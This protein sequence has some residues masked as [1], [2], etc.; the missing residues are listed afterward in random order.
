MQLCSESFMKE[1][2]PFCIMSMVHDAD[3]IPGVHGHDFIELV[4]VVS[5]QA[6]HMFQHESYQ[7]SAG[8]VFIINPGEVH[9]YS[10]DPGHE[11]EII[12]CLFL[13]HLIKDSLLS[14]L[15]ISH[16]MD[17]FYVHPF[18]N[19]NDRFHHRLN[20]A[21][22]EAVR[23]LSI[24]Q[25]MMYEMDA[26]QT[27]Y[28]TLIRMQMVELL[29]ILSRY[30]QLSREQKTLCH[31][32]EN[33]LIAARICGYLERHY[34]QKI[35]LNQLSDLFHIST[36]QLNRVFK[37]ET[38]MSVIEKVHQ[39]RLTRAKALLSET[40][41]KVISIAA[42]V[43]YEDPAFFSRLFSRHIGCSPSHYRSRI[44]SQPS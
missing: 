38:G 39:I 13:P 1:K 5:G 42:L 14:E 16:S 27:G 6:R 2:F 35:T 25:N 34:D 33:A 21:G 17:Y 8:D 4:Y 26:K 40:T 43:G 29:V 10:V 32:R 44:S 41:E 28:P 37:Q 12:N 15:E 3:H 30:Y 11:L 9:N 19:T 20:L 36:R 7:L 23:V 31:A 22:D 18:L 24:L